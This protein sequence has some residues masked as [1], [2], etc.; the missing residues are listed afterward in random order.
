MSDAPKTFRP[1]PISTDLKIP[2]V[3]EDSTC[4]HHPT[5]TVAKLSCNTCLEGAPLPLPPSP[6]VPDHPASPSSSGH[7]FITPTP[8]QHDIPIPPVRIC[9]DPSSSPNPTFSSSSISTPTSPLAT[10]SRKRKEAGRFRS[11]GSTPS[12]S[13]LSQTLSF[14]TNS[15]GLSPTSSTSSTA[16]APNAPRF[17]LPPNYIRYPGTHQEFYELDSDDETFLETV[18]AALSSSSASSGPSALDADMLERIIENLELSAMDAKKAGIPFNAV[19]SIPD[20]APKTEEQGII[21]R[22]V[23][24]VDPERPLTE[25]IAC[26]ICCDTHDTHDNQIVFCDGCDISVH[27]WC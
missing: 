4:Y 5:D 13:N 12:R 15:D 25:E 27:Q 17:R 1:R 26:C 2:V 3:W 7:W 24:S 11:L 6:S 18:S 14:N 23:A 9:A 16:S 20:W 22:L 19:L 10:R 8:Q 21:P